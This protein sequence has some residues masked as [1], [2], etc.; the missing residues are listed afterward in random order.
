MKLFRHKI[1]FTVI[2]SVLVVLFAAFLAAYFITA[3]FFPAVNMFFGNPRT[4]DVVKGDLVYFCNECGYEYSEEAGCPEAGVA[5]HV[6]WEKVPAGFVCPDCGAEKSKF[7]LKDPPVYFSS[8]YENADGQTILAEDLAM[9]E[10]TEG[11][12]AVLLWNEN[13]ALPLSSGNKVSLLGRGSRDLVETG[14]GSGWI[15][16]GQYSVDLKE[17]LEAAGITV[18][19]TLWDFYA[20]KEKWQDR[21]SACTEGATWSVNELAWSSYTDA[22]KSSFSSYGDAAI[23]VL[24]RT[25]GEYSDLHTQ[26]SDAPSDHAGNYLALTDKERTLLDEVSNLKNAG[27]F[28]K[29]I[30]LM[31]SANFIQFDVLGTYRNMIDAAMWIGEVGTSGAAAVGKL[32][33]GELNPSGH[34]PDTIPY[35]HESAPSTKNDGNYSYLEYNQYKDLHGRMVERQ[36]EYMVYQEG[37]YIGYKYYET[38]Y[39][40]CV[41]GQGGADAPAG[42]IDGDAWDY[43]KEVAFPFGHGLSYT[44]FEYSGFSASRTRD[45]DI[46]VKVTVKNTGSASGKDAVE[47]YLQR[48]YTAF[49]VENGIEQ[50]AVQLAGFVKTDLLQAGESAEY[51]VL[52]DESELKT[53]DSVFYRTY[54]IEGGDYYFAVGHDAHDALNNILAAKGKTEAD[55]MTD[56]GNGGLAK[57]LSVKEDL[58]KYAVSEYTGEEIV[59]RFDRGDWNT[60]DGSDGKEV[61]Y[62]TRNDWSG[63]YPTSNAVLT[64][65]QLLANDLTWDKDVVEDPDAVMPLYGQ[66]NG[67]TLI[68]LKDQPYDSELWDQLLDQMTW[69]EQATICAKAYHMVGSA[70]SIVLPGSNQEN[71]PVGLTSRS[72][73][74]R[75]QG[76]DY[77]YVSYPCVPVWGA[78][79]NA[80]LVERLGKHMGEDLLYTGYNGIYGPGLNLHR[81]GFG[82][83]NWEYPSEDTLLAGKI[84]SAACRGI[85]SK[86]CMAYVKHLALNDLETNRRHA[87]IWSNEQA[88]REIYL[89]P[90][91][92]AFT[93]GGAS[94]CMNSFTRVGPDWCGSCKELMT[95]V[96]R[97]EWGWTGIMI[98]DWDQNDGP[99]SKIDGLLAGTDSY[100]GNVSGDV[101][102]P[103]KDS[104]TACMALRNSAKHIAYTILHTNAMNG[105]DS[106]DKIIH[107]VP[108]WQQV[109]IGLVWATGILALFSLGLTAAAYI[110]SAREHKEQP[111]EEK[112]EKE[113]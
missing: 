82:G 43:A 16:S 8:D 44:T 4:Y 75:P 78:T 14:S 84:G 49:D 33:A 32:L 6:K 63:T 26:G 76:N 83:R 64:M 53:Y 2:S 100:D 28:K 87:S 112:E 12:G 11:E 96:L 34:L 47:V 73:F 65:T 68:M 56:A 23:V 81:T 94:A 9:I 40:D 92:L 13:G 5:A 80:E 39:E 1:L 7:L 17:G 104:P 109:L 60:Y 35:S 42:S 25:G 27:T 97:K 69:E 36:R 55:G 30:L 51:T 102:L 31:N 45:G 79:F 59:N 91:E 74:A 52:V 22:V 46:E 57:S 62:L 48:P 18:N 108:A 99:M 10:E 24:C 110:V 71:G 41:L 61:V 19:S 105:I 38:R 66:D 89:R 107:I 20:G 50:S 111:Q 90:F 98:S 21:Q 15:A 67:L 101:F 106:G 54:I 37:I 86:G 85:E 95:D 93:E 3:S 113:N 29:V 70:Q 58:I 88:T 72:D 103:Y 77:V